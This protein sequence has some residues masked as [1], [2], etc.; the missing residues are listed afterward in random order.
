MCVEMASPMGSESIVYC[1]D[2]KYILSAHIYSSLAFARLLYCD[3]KNK[4]VN[5]YQ[6]PGNTPHQ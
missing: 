5:I 2:H 1:N 3:N 4:A 6:G